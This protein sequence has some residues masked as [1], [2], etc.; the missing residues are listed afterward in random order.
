MIIIKPF[1]LE[2]ILLSITFV[3]GCC[4]EHQQQEPPPPPVYQAVTTG[5]LYNVSAGIY[6]PYYWINEKKFPLAMG[7]S[8][9][10]FAYGLAKKDNDLYFAGTFSAPHPRDGHPV[11]LPCYWKNGTKYDLPVNEINFTERCTANDLKWFNGALYLLGDADLQ[12]IVWK[13]KNGVVS[14]IHLPVDPAA[15]SVSK[16]SNLEVY[17]NKLYFAGNEKK[18]KNGQVLFDAGYWTIDAMDKIVFTILEDDLAYALCFGMAVSSKGLYITG[19]YA[20]AP[21]AEKPV[22]WTKQG[23]LAAAG[24]L[25]AGTQRLNESV[26]DAHG[27]IYL[28]IL[29]IQP[30]QPHVWKLPAAGGIESI[31]PLVPVAAKGFCNNLAVLD[32]QFAYAY[33]YGLDAQYEA[34]LVWNNKAIPL[35]FDRK[36]FVNLYRTAIYRE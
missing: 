24:Q 7:N 6:E 34:V 22:I 8:S 11:I 26:V 27:T 28:N 31:K 35:E 33:S 10:A 17:D 2:L 1:S 20:T 18:K 21:G 36:Q 13:I 29:D 23:H 14:M 25:N 32:D 16:G 4:K 30:Y 15:C 9:Q 3:A 19:E 12:P 5:A